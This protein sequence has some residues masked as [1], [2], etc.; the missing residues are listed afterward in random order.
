MTSKYRQYGYCCPDWLKN[1]NIVQCNPGKDLCTPVSTA[2]KSDN[3]SK[4]LY[5]SY[6]VGMNS[7][8]VEICGSQAHVRAYADKSTQVT[9][10]NAGVLKKRKG[11]KLYESCHYIIDFSANYRPETSQIAVWIES[12]TNA[13]V[14]VYEGDRQNPTSRLIKEWDLYTAAKGRTILIV[15]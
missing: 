12:K 14:F 1:S 5:M 9:F 6:A 13:N 10:T 7:N 11:S 8:R 2:R 15:S 4:A 3:A